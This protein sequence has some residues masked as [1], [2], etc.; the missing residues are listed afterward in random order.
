ML[1]CQASRFCRSSRFIAAGGPAV[2]GEVGAAAAGCALVGAEAAKEHKSP[3]RRVAS[4]MMPKAL[5]PKP[6][7]ELE[8]AF[9]A[10][11]QGMHPTFG[12]L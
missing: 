1:L 11:L 8:N 3:T 4:D 12:C 5:E 2:P 7:T 6:R 10:Y 9:M